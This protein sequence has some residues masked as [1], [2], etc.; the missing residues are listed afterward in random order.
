M[1]SMCRIL[2]C[3]ALASIERPAAAAANWGVNLG[4]STL[5]ID[6][7]TYADNGAN[8]FKGGGGIWD[9]NDPPNVLN[10]TQNLVIGPNT[11]DLGAFLNPVARDRDLSVPFDTSASAVGVITINGLGSR[12]LVI[13]W[14]LNTLNDQIGG[15]TFLSDSSAF[16]TSAIEAT[17]A[18][19]GPGTPLQIN[20]DWNYF[21]T[22]V[23]DHEGA[24]EDPES[25]SGDLGFIDDQG[26]GPGNLFA[27]LVNDSTDINSGSGSLNLTTSNPLSYLTINLGGGST[28]SMNSPGSG[29]PLDEDLAGSDFIGHLTL[30]IVPEPS[31]LAL[32][33]LG[34]AATWFAGVRR[35][36]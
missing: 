2:L 9:E 25:A 7:D 8:G 4:A 11:F 26:G 5:D 22:A 19:V 18:G 33:A 1:N 15:D 20:Y 32:L 30:T 10:F 16:L 6:A 24:L 29:F 3:L 36:R 27:T 17:I 13:D 34:A 35:R 31:S 28:A 14:R 23:E 21:A 12:T